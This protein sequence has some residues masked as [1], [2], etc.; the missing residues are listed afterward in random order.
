MKRSAGL[1]IYSLHVD[2]QLKVLLVHPGGPFYA[3]KDLG[4]WSIPKGEYEEGEDPLTVA[5]REFEEETGNTI[6]VLSPIALPPVKLASGKQ[7]IAFAVQGDPALCFIR[8]NTFEMEWP[9]RTGKRQSFAEVD[10]AAWFTLD[11][12]MVKIHPAQVPFLSFL[13]TVVAP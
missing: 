7:V 8:S 10:R 6:E 12:A 4:V 2:E 13:Q 1:V 5:V 3:K 11:E 9:P